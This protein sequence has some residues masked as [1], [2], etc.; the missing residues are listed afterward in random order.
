[1]GERIKDLSSFVLKGQKVAIELNKRDPANKEYDIHV[2]LPGIRCHV[3]DHEFMQIAA[4]VAEAGRK[5]NDKKKG[6]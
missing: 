2:E 6:Q 5:L 4:C 3:T 1:M